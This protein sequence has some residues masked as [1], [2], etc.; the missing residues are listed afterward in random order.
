M[1]SPILV[2]DLYSNC[3]LQ[4]PDGVDWTNE[5]TM[6][7]LL[8]LDTAEFCLRQQ[9]GEIF[10]GS[11]ASVWRQVL[12]RKPN[13]WFKVVGNSMIPTLFAGDQV[14][15]QPLIEMPELGEIV[16]AE[17]NGRLVLH[18]VIK[19]D[20]SWVILQGDNSPKPDQPIG[21][22]QVVGVVVDKNLRFKSRMIALYKY[23]SQ[24]RH[25]SAQVKTL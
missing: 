25:G 23:I 11:L 12:Y 6:A 13:F 3:I 9:E 5:V 7:Q 1:N 20:A 18:R 17:I 2:V 15:I 24:K 4:V 10:L 21:I 22:Q 8:G 19:L 16:L 14:R